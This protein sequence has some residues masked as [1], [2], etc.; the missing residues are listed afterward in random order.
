MPRSRYVPTPADQ[1]RV[2]ELAAIGLSQDDIASQFRLPLRRFQRIFKHELKDGAA[3]GREHA[4]RKLHGIAI[5][6]E[7]VAALTFWVKSQCGWRDTGTAPSAPTIIRKVMLFAPEQP[8]NPQPAAHSP[9][10]DARLG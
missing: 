3:A 4:L 2:R 5:A 9:T 7:N 6:G 8:K 10:P 1:L